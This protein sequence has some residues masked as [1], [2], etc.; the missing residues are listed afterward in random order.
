MVNVLR[1]RKG[2]TLDRDDG[3]PLP[4]AGFRILSVLDQIT[5]RFGID[6][7]ISSGT[8]SHTHGSHPTGDAYDVSVRGLSAQ[9]IHDI[10]DELEGSLGPLFTV[11]YEVPT[12]PSDPTLRAIAYVSAAAT[13]PHFHVQKKKGTVFPPTEPRMVV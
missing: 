13:G 7:E 3:E 4:P 5:I 2:V 12:L 8:D 9:Q 10:K 1:A 6:L 11:L